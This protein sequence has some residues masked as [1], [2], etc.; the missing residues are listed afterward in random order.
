MKTYK[1][2]G[3]NKTYNAGSIAEQYDLCDGMRHCMG[4]MP[5]VSHKSNKQRSKTST[6]DVEDN[7]GPYPRNAV[8]K[9]YRLS[10]VEFQQ[11]RRW[12]FAHYHDE[13]SS[14]WEE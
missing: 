13:D 2:Y 4:Y 8:G 9:P 1:G 14:V 6:D 12:V 5:A 7:E 11:V 10:S 3:R